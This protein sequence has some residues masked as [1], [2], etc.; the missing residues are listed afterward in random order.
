M[1]MKDEVPCDNRWNGG[2]YLLVYSPTCPKGSEDQ[3][4]SQT[5][6]ITNQMTEIAPFQLS[7]SYINRKMKFIF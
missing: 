2:M 6:M 4:P 1:P 7:A 3:H 5:H